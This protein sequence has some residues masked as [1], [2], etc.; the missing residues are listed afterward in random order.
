M[1]ELDLQAEIEKI[2]HSSET[3]KY[4]HTK[5][6]KTSQFGRVSADV[7]KFQAFFFGVLSG[8]FWIFSKIVKPILLKVTGPIG[9]YLLNQYIKLWNK[10]VFKKDEYNLP[11]FS[12][13]R[14]GIMILATGV[15]LWYLLIPSVHLVV[16]TGIY[17]ATV[18]KNETTFLN[19]SQEL[20]YNDGSHAIEG[21]SRLPCS[22]SDAFYMR[23]TSSWFNDIWSIIHTGWFFYPDQ[24]A[25]GIP[26]DISEC[27]VTTYGIRLRIFGR[28][29]TYPNLLSYTCIPVA[30]GKAYIEEHKGEKHND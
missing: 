8:L 5:S 16:D 29:L 12:Q 6:Q 27:K 20:N 26:Y 1:E 28:S 15:F 23:T 30:G 11:I 4:N 3:F 18:Q 21:C 10:V 25:S 13:I 7:T 14:A 24:V 2:K 22:S 19:G 17:F 9:R